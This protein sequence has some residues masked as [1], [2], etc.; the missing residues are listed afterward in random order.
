M[1][2]TNSEGAS[3]ILFT[4]VCNLRVLLDGNLV[5]LDSVTS[6]QFQF[7]CDNIAVR[8]ILSLFTSSY[9]LLLLLL[10]LR[11]HHHHLHLHNPHDFYIS[12][13]AGR[14]FSLKSILTGWSKTS[15]KP[16]GLVMFVY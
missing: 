14:H 10:L 12:L 16:K 2:I 6:F 7:M 15:L 4:G 9:S 11:Y 8:N 3:G 1:S 5:C 13:W